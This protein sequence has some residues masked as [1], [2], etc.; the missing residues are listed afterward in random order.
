M[1][2]ILLEV[3]HP[4]T[5]QPVLLTTYGLTMFAGVSAGLGLAV[6]WAPRRRLP[7][8]DV[9]AAG[10]LAVAG[11]LL[12][13]KIL[14]W[15]LNGPALVARYGAMA[16][17]QSGGLVFYGGV[18]GGAL[19]FVLYVR[20]SGL[21]LADAF[22]V[23][24]PS[25][26]LGQAFG[27]VGCFFAGCCHGRPAGDFPLAFVYPPGHLA[28]AGVPLY[29]IQLIEAGGLLVIALVLG[30]VL[31]RGRG[32]RPGTV[33]LLWATAYPVL[34]LFTEMLRGDDRGAMWGPL[35]PSQGL[36]L[37]LLLGVAA[38]ALL[39][40]PRTSRPGVDSTSPDVA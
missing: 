30:W 9:F 14:Y 23:G 18:F 26:A 3:R 36:S 2:W 24:A 39:R 32:L 4:L 13:A 29:P 21:S 16:L 5:G 27:R 31:L 11:G 12:G 25:L 38:V 1:N 19:A 6:A 7:R 10:L 35:S 15:I 8:F 37:A 28:P 22:D 20:Q 33:G 17:F 34:R 40:G